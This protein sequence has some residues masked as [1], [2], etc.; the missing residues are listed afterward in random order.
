MNAI[1][2]G[3][4]TVC[5]VMMLLLLPGLDAAEG[6]SQIM[7]C[8]VCTAND[9]VCQENPFNVTLDPN[10]NNYI[11][12][13]DSTKKEDTCFK[14]V[15]TEGKIQRGCTSDGETNDCPPKGIA[16]TGSGGLVSS[17]YRCYTR[18]CNSALQLGAQ[19]LLILG[20]ISLLGIAAAFRQHF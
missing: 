5:L 4:S 3:L 8:F 17:C 12:Y 7:K 14:Y 18:A 10:L 6:A 16:K 1:R 9:A 11:R 13:C 2:M 15:N 19:S 20:T